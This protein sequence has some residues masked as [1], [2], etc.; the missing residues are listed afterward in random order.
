MMTGPAKFQKENQHPKKRESVD[1]QQDSTSHVSPGPSQDL[2]R[3]DKIIKARSKE[4]KRKVK[5]VGPG[6]ILEP[7]RQT[8]S[9][10]AR[11]YA[12]PYDQCEETIVSIEGMWSHIKHVH[13][14]FSYSCSYC[15]FT[16]KNFDSL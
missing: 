10:G 3:D 5:K 16:T 13:E 8:S 15:A 14:L 4:G 12:C 1:V 6:G 7:V 11:Y 9:T 2:I